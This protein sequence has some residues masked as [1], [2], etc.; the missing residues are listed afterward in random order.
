MWWARTGDHKGPPTTSSPRSPL[1]YDEAARPRSCIVG[2][3]EDVDV[4]MG[5]LWLPVRAPHHL[6]SP[7]LECIGLCGC[8]SMPPPP[9]FSLFG[10]Y[11]P[12]WGPCLGDR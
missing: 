2:A 11:C 3:G 10:M 6:S 9:L 5:P 7:Y 1:R 8:P 4:G 12:L